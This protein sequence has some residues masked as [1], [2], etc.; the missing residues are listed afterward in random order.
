M[1]GSPT[2]GFF[3]SVVAAA[4]AEREL[5]LSA[6]HSE[7]LIFTFSVERRHDAVTI[8]RE[9]LHERKIVRRESH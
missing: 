1:Q 3:L 2:E 4:S 6:L 5:E 9:F 7:S 8:R